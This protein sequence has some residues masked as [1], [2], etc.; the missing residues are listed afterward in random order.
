M[1]GRQFADYC[2]SFYGP[3]QL[4][5]HF[6]GHSL[7]MEELEEA[8]IE[9]ASS[10]DYAADSFDRE[11]VRDIIIAKRKEGVA[12]RKAMLDVGDLLK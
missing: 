4:Y 11:A 6:F 3:H 9:R 10:P 2:W 12:K 8:V 1:N 5:G 7:T